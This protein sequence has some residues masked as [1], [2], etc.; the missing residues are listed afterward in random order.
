MSSDSVA[1]C[2][3][4][5]RMRLLVAIEHDGEEMDFTLVSEIHRVLSIGVPSI[6]NERDLSTYFAPTK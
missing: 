2:N 4:D 3:P 1:T 5:V 6:F